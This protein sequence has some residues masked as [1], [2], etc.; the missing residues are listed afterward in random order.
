VIR[1]IRFIDFRV[2]TWAVVVVATAG[3]FAGASPAGAAESPALSTSPD[4]ER[5]ILPLLYGRCFSCHSEKVAE[6]KAELRLDSA[7]SI[8]ESGAITTG[9]PDE[10]ELLRRVSLP[11]SDKGLMPPLKGGGLPLNEAERALVRTWIA[12]GA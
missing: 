7:E 9:K 10:S 12:E 6:P 4:F 5:Q 11:H 1:Q 3:L 2:S 8:L